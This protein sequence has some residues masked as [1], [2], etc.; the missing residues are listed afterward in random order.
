MVP[1][2]ISC[3]QTSCM[4]IG[5]PSGADVSPNGRAWAEF[6]NGTWAASGTFQDGGPTV[7]SCFTASECV[8]LASRGETSVFNGTAWSQV[9]TPLDIPYG[10][11]LTNLQCSSGTACEAQYSGDLGN[12]SATWNG[13]SWTGIPLELG[14]HSIGTGQAGCS[15][16]LKMCIAGSDAGFVLKPSGGNWTGVKPAPSLSAYSGVSVAQAGCPASD[17]CVILTGQ[18]VIEA[19]DAN[20]RAVG[21]LA[22]TSSMGLLSGLTCFPGGCYAVDDE[23]PIGYLIR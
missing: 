5:S 12:M 11:Y 7:V 6:S 9:G 15:R 3:A 1:T 21:Q 20:G 10:L 2:A 18:G 14:S 23:R 13:S 17:V 8:G 22:P 4:V 16:D 19:I